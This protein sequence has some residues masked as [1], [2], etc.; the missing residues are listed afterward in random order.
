M[1][2]IKTKL[3]SLV[4]FATIV[5]G[6]KLVG[7]DWHT[8]PEHRPSLDY[9]GQI[10]DE[11]ENK[12]PHKWLIP[13]GCCSFCTRGH[14]DRCGNKYRELDRP[15]S[16]CGCDD[17]SCEGLLVRYPDVDW[18][19]IADRLINE[20]HSIAVRPSTPWTEIGIYEI[21]ID[22]EVAAQS[23]SLNEA[24]VLA[25]YRFKKGLKHDPK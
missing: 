9:P 25:S 2:P 20:G 21:T 10:I 17:D 5:L 15:I 1:N 12:G 24:V 18:N 4:E 13:P 7:E 8:S 22:G 11:W 23:H 19:H 6:Y 14:H 16:L 3:P